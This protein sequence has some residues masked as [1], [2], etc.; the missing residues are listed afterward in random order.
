MLEVMNCSIHQ[1]Q[2]STSLIIIPDIKDTQAK[3]KL[4]KNITLNST[5]N[6]IKI[7]EMAKQKIKIVV[8]IPFVLLKDSRVVVFMTELLYFSK[9]GIKTIFKTNP[10]KFAPLISKTLQNPRESA[11]G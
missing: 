6:I 10:I 8:I 9:V 1:L 5:P 3:I 2:D 4:T 11:R 7:T